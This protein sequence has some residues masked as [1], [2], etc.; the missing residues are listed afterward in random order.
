MTVAQWRVSFAQRRNR[1][2]ESTSASL[3]LTGFSPAEMPGS[4]YKPSHSKL[5]C[6]MRGTNPSISERERAW[7]NPTGERKKV[8]VELGGSVAQKRCRFGEGATDLHASE[9]AVAV[10]SP[11]TAPPRGRH[12]SCPRPGCRR[13]TRAGGVM[14]TQAAFALVLEGDRRRGRK[15]H[16]PVEPGG[17]VSDAARGNERLQILRAWKRAHGSH[18]NAQHHAEGQSGGRAHPIPPHCAPAPATPSP[19]TPSTPSS[20]A[21]VQ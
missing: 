2:G 4:R 12:G 13:P 3:G 8:D 5:T 6:R 18:P 11:R 17:R 20:H 21:K 10:L 7:A 14:D 16:R 15:E 1:S 9:L 19:F